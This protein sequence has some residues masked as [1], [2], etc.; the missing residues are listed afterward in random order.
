MMEHD[1]KVQLWVR[2]GEKIGYACKSLSAY[3]HRITELV[4]ITIRQLKYVTH[5]R[6]HH[7]RQVK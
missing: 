3:A 6:P 2:R 1:R 7:T 5:E 4:S